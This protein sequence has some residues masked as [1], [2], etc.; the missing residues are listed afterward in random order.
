MKFDFIGF[1]TKIGF[2]T[3]SQG[4]LKVELFSPG[5]YKFQNLGNETLVIAGY[6]CVKI[7]GFTVLHVKLWSEDNNVL[8]KFCSFE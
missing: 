3:K 2:N 7:S 1:V 8:H 4:T 5:I 6:E